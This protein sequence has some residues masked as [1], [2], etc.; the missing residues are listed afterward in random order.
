[1]ILILFIK[2]KK[3][4]LEDP[5]DNEYRKIGRVGRLFEEYNRDYYKPKLID[6]GFA[7]EVNNYIKHISEG[8][9][10]EKL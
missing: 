7:G 6:R 9:K 3:L 5:D 10:D 2:K 1:M 8:D 4:N